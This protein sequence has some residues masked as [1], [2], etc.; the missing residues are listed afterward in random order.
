MDVGM[1]FPHPLGEVVGGDVLAG[2]HQLREQGS[3]AGGHAATALADEG[4]E[5]IH[6]VCGHVDRV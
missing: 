4:K 6:A 1:P 5:S 3:T 2:P